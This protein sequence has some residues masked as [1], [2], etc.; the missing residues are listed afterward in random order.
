MRIKLFPQKSAAQARLNQAFTLIELLVVIAIISIL[1]A[2]LIPVVGIVRE[3]SHSATCVSNL[4]QLGVAS[5]SY[6][7]EHQGAIPSYQAQNDSY[8]ASFWWYKIIPYLGHDADEITPGDA[9]RRLKTLQCPSALAMHSPGTDSYYDEVRTYAINTL[10]NYS[11]SSQNEDGDREYSDI[12]LLNIPHPGETA[13][14]MD[15]SI[16]SD[17]PFWAFTVRPSQLLPTIE[18]DFVHK[19]PSI[20]VVYVDGHVGSVT[21]EDMPVESNVFWKPTGSLF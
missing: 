2:I 9:Q 16:G 18:A 3:S 17:L 4:R 20:N 14:Y 7:N 15:G 19:G 12:P 8:P 6:A 21:P 1:A 10:L 5:L 13:L 11:N